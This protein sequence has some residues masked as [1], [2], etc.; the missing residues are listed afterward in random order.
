MES[1]DV[2]CRGVDGTFV[3]IVEDKE[4]RPHAHRDGRDYSFDCNFGFLR[5][6]FTR[7]RSFNTSSA[8]T[9]DAV[10]RLLYGPAV[11]AGIAFLAASNMHGHDPF[12][13]EATIHSAMEITQ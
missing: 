1:P 9:P 4:T 7:V 2:S 12:D 6:T 5:F 10:F 13:W 3:P 11:F 8:K